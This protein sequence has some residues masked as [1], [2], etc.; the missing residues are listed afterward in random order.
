MKCFN[1]LTA[2]HFLFYT[3]IWRIQRRGTACSYLIRRHT[4]FSRI[5]HQHLQLFLRSDH[6]V[7]VLQATEIYEW[8]GDG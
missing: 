8:N 1:Y 5:R 4:S 7:S 6:N 3:N 2:L